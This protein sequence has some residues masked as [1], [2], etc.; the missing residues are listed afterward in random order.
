MVNILRS[1]KNAE[2]GVPAPIYSLASIAHA[3]INSQNDHISQNRLS[4]GIVILRGSPLLRGGKK[5]PL[6]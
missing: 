2:N 6:K 3:L 5:Y 4:T 1:A